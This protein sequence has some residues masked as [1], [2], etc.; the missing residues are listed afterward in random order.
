[1]DKSNID[2]RRLAICYFNGSIS[3][4]EE[5]ILFQ[6]VK[7]TAENERLFRKWEQEWAASARLM[8]EVDKEW[9]KL[10]SRMS[11]RDIL[12]NQRISGAKRKRAYMFVAAAVIAVLIITGG[13]Y[14]VQQYVYTEMSD[15][16]FALQTGMGEKSRIVLADGT[17]VYLNAGSTLKYSGNFN[18]KNREV[19]LSGEAYFEVT[20]LPGDIPFTVQTDQYSILVKGTKF[21]VSSYQ[22]DEQY[23]TALL[24]GSIDILYKGNHIPVAP[25]ELM[26]LNKQNGK[27]SRERGQTAQYTSWIEGRVEYDKITLSELAV[28]L[29]R[30]Y[31]VDI[32]L[33]NSLNKDVAFRISLR[34][35]E[36]IGDILKALSKVIPI[37]YERSGRDIYIRKQ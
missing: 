16:I 36:T 11:I 22:E 19:I 12:D 18:A 29:S 31:D 1:M 34:N 4:A 27:L 25:G 33:D 35:E 2:Y 30:K 7:A 10:Q 13:I 8:P 6:Y 32:T 9:K 14:G 26:K 28:R 15:N 21:N 24:E 17:I 3:L 20:K 5:E 37:R 23:T